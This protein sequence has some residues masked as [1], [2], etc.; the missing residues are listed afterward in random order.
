AQLRGGAGRAG[1]LRRG[2]L[3]GGPCRIGASGRWSGPAEELQVGDAT[4]AALL[5]AEDRADLDVDAGDAVG[6]HGEDLE[7][8]VVVEGEVVRRRGAGGVRSPQRE[9]HFL[10]PGLG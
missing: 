3:I 7:A 8:G 1:P 9:V 10:G 6:P 2:R 4:V 5:A